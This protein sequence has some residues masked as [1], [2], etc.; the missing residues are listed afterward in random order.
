M[1]YRAPVITAKLVK[2]L[3]KV[4]VQLLH[5]H[6]LNTI[7]LTSGDD[8]TGWGAAVGANYQVAEPLKVSADV[9]YVKGNSNYLY[10]NNS[11]FYVNEGNG[12]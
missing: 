8:K 4:K 12:N 2:A 5:V 3:R 1:T 9:S 6:W 11:A 7:K 10:G